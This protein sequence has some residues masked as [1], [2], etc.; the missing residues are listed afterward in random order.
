MA[1]GREIQLTGVT[2]ESLKTQRESERGVVGETEK[3]Q[4]DDKNNVFFNTVVGNGYEG[5][6]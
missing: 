6:S 4:K 1:E 3:F 2:N 5:R